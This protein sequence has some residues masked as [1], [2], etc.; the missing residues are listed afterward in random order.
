MSDKAVKLKSYETCSAIQQQLFGQEVGEDLGCREGNSCNSFCSS[1]SRD[2]LQEQIADTDQ[3]NRALALF[4]TYAGQGDFADY[5][6]VSEMF[7]ALISEDIALKERASHIFTG[8]GY[9]Y[10]NQ[11]YVTADSTI[12]TE[13]LN[14]LVD[15]VTEKNT[16]IANI[17]GAAL[18]QGSDRLAAVSH[19]KQYAVHPNAI[20]TLVA[21][22]NDRD[23][24]VAVAAKDALKAIAEDH[25]E[26]ISPAMQTRAEKYIQL[27]FEALK[28]MVA[29]DPGTVL[30]HISD[31]SD[32]GDIVPALVAILG[33]DQIE[34][35]LDAKRAL[36]EMR[37]KDAEAISP[38]MEALIEEKIGMQA[39]AIQRMTESSDAKDRLQAVQ[40]AKEF[41]HPMTL[42]D[43]VAPLLKDPDKT[44]V[45]GVLI[46]IDA[47]SNN[48]D[49]TVTGAV[50]GLLPQIARIVGLP[51]VTRDH[52]FTDEFDRK[53]LFPVLCQ[54][55]RSSDPEK[56]ASAAKLLGDCIDRGAT[57]VL[58]RLVKDSN[59]DV[60]GAA[61]ASLD[62]ATV[63]VSP[64]QLRT[65]ARVV[66]KA[67]LSAEESFEDI[68]EEKLAF[69]HLCDE[70]KNEEDIEK[71]AKAIKE[72]G[73]YA[74]RGSVPILIRAAT[75][76]DKEIVEA[77]LEALDTVTV[78]TEERKAH[79]LTQNQLKTIAGVVGK[80]NLT[81]EDLFIEAYRKNSEFKELAI[82]AVDFDNATREEAAEELKG[83]V[84][85]GAV[86]V[87]IQL[88]KDPF[89][90]VAMTAFQTLTEITKVE[91]EAVARYVDQITP[92][93]NMKQS[94][95]AAQTR[96]ATTLIGVV[97][98]APGAFRSHLIKV[99]RFNAENASDTMVK[100]ASIQT[101]GRL[102]ASP[103]T[104]ETGCRNGTCTKQKVEA[105][106]Y[107]NEW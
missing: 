81:A 28:G 13:D 69:E 35:A 98:V 99:L 73:E 71:R 74:H 26:Y 80:D 36:D 70:V 16:S 61:L 19:L 54:D 59:E 101:L 58:M 31:Y 64:S 96:E 94:P 106:S 91:P 88:T 56:R 66:G 97:G 90:N 23:F 62:R 38:E 53:D 68:Y 37:K 24:G 33:C 18:L 34:T 3:Q 78:G 30:T 17:T 29:T 65:I 95:S 46:Q 43:L 57:P 77:A 40:Y 4:D 89:S 20:I 8:D 44:V 6:S 9:N 75:S 10:N 100:A 72:L 63:T 103:G 93:L 1:I 22:T 87:L 21:L 14:L 32:V 76:S 42:I 41:L 12:S 47:L 49:T 105:A 52:N 92:L 25:P 2:D 51:K 86:P 27:K 50:D 84:G 85:Y 55:A 102:G 107:H 11:D 48:E 104:P 7:T 79:P 82:K 45:R 39:Q 60:V 5:F 83:Y 67:D 15:L